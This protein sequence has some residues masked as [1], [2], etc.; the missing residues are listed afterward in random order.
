MCI[1]LGD[2]INQQQTVPSLHPVEL[3]L[4][5]KNMK[6]NVLFVTL[7]LM[8]STTNICAANVRVSTQPENSEAVKIVLEEQAKHVKLE[9]NYIRE[10]VKYSCMKQI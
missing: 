1:N 3:P 6:R 7:A 9:N 5:E 2:T 8:L 10:T 4:L